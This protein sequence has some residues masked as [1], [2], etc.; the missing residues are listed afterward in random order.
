MGVRV[1]NDAKIREQLFY[2][3]NNQAELIGSITYIDEKMSTS[4]LSDPLRDLFEGP[5]SE[6]LSKLKNHHEMISVLTEWA[7][8]AGLHIPTD[9]NPTRND[10][11]PILLL[12]V[13]IHILQLK[14]NSTPH[15][16]ANPA[17][18]STSFQPATQLSHH[19]QHHGALQCWLCIQQ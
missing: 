3:V 11:H 5:L 19:S 14:R 15:Q 9:S 17:A 2:A 13:A 6:L 12:T 18:T 7:A 10:L 4:G 16:P 8:Q 1:V